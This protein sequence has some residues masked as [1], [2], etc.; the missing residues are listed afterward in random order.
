MP[1]GTSYRVTYHL[2][3]YQASTMGNPDKKVT[4]KPASHT[5]PWMKEPSYNK[6]KAN[7]PTSHYVIERTETKR[8]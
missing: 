4:S 3:P 6:W 8:D 2:K 1:S 5:T 7:H